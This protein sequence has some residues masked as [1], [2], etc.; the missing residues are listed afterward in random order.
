MN[1]KRITKAGSIGIPV[2]LRREQN[3]RTGD[4]MDVQVDGNGRVVLTPH[5]PRCVFCSSTEAVTLYRGK[6]VCRSCAVQIG[7][8]DT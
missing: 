3:I 7:K 8:E 5:L 6:G 2:G 4:A 1:T